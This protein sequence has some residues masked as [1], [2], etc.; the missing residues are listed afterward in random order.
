[1]SPPPAELPSEEILAFGPDS[2]CF[3]PRTYRAEASSLFL[4]MVI[5]F[6]TVEMT[7]KNQNQGGNSVARK[8]FVVTAQTVKSMNQ[9][10][11]ARSLKYELEFFL[12]FFFFL[13]LPG[14]IHTL[15]CVHV[16]V[17]VR[18]RR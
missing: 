13:N 12:L 14:R 17:R 15:G 1:M 2:H 8:G 4:P 18:E 3:R 16:G 5:I 10:H 9:R 11:I 6:L 7:G